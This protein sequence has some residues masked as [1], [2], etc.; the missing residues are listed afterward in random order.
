MALAFLVIML[1]LRAGGRWRDL[2][3]MRAQVGRR[4]GRDVRRVHRLAGVGFGWVAAL[5]APGSVRSFL[6]G[7]PRSGVGAGQIGLLLGLGDHTQ[8]ALDV[9]QPVGTADRVGDRA[10][11]HVAVLAAPD[12]SGARPRHGDGRV[13]AARPGDPALVPAVGGA[14]AGGGHRGPALSQGDDLAHGAVLGDDHA[15][16]RDDPGYV[17]VQAVLVAVIVV[18]RPGAAGRLRRYRYY[19]VD[20]DPV[21]PRRDARRRDAA[22]SAGRQRTG[23]R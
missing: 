16:R 14:A 6:S 23:P 15:Q 1:A 21:E 19:P 20:A 7:R 2:L 9:M 12:Q 17:I 18:G 13:R 11:D 22:S 10:G 5:G 8:A 3:A 4:R